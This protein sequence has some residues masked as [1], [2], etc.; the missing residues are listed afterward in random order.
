LAGLFGFLAFLVVTATS[1]LTRGGEDEMR[2]ALVEAVHLQQ[3]RATDSQ[4][5]QMFDYFLT[6]Q[7]MMVV[8]GLGFVMMGIAFVLL[9]G[10]GAALSASLLR[11]K[12]PPER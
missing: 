10:A 8:L 2:Q 5:R 4:V 3:A 7:G 6:P 11:R 12:D 1:T 9:S